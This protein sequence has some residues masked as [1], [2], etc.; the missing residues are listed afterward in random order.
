MFNKG[1][2]IGG[3]IIFVAAAAF[4]FYWYSLG[5]GKPFP[6]LELPEKEKQCIES[7]AFMRANHMRLLDAWRIAVVRDDLLIYT[8][9]KGKKFEMNLHKTC[10]G[11]H[12]SSDR[13]CNRCHDYNDVVPPCWNCHVAPSETVGGQ[14]PE[15]GIQRS[16]VIHVNRKEEKS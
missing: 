16:E 13:F 11:C 5:Q 8:S 6:Q 7:V 12:T 3:I 14:R 10:M 9:A 4:P 1:W 15:F 2:V